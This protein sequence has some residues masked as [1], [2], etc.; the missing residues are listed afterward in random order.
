MA[1]SYSG[2]C[3]SG[4][5]LVFTK[6]NKI[7][8][9][10]SQNTYHV[11]IDGLWP[12]KYIVLH[13]SIQT[14]RGHG[15]ARASQAHPTSVF[16]ETQ[17]KGAFWDKMPSPHYSREKWPI[18]NKPDSE[19]GIGRTTKKPTDKPPADL[20]SNRQMYPLLEGLDIMLSLP[21]DDLTFPKLIHNTARQLTRLPPSTG[22]IISTFTAIYL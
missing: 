21:Q 5:F 8:P 11:G 10:G 3:P 14:E 20:A 1:D 7:L 15:D 12:F 2:S 6:I 22:K 19:G 9:R 13:P 4:I 16:I 18:S 17:Q